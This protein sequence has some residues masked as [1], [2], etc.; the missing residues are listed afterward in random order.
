MI[1]TSFRT[2][3]FLF[4][5][6]FIPSSI[7]VLAFFHLPSNPVVAPSAGDPNDE[8]TTHREK[9]K[10][11]MTCSSGKNLFVY[12]LFSVC[13]FPADKLADEMEDDSGGV[14]KMYE[15]NISEAF[16]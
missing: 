14:K 6:F 4:S 1:T 12:S 9:S 15:R 11:I 16:T 3:L 7:L 13:T 10:S 2:S 5:F 8:I